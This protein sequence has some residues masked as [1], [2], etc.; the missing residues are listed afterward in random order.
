M[1]ARETGHVAGPGHPARPRSSGASSLQPLDWF[2]VIVPTALAAALLLYDLGGRSLWLDEA[3][4]FTTASQHGSALW[5][6]ALND[7]GNMVLYYLGM[8]VVTGALGTSEITLRL[9]SALAAIATVPTAFFLLRRLFDRRAA[10]FGAAFEAV[11]MPVVYWGQQARGYSV[12]AF[13][14]SASTL[15]FVVAVQDK[16]RLAYVAYVV[17]SV[18]AVY[19]VLLS[20]LVLVAHVASLLAL[21]PDQVPRRQL[22]ACY[23]AICVLC[24]PVGLVA[25]AHGTAPVDWVTPFGS[26]VGPAARGLVEFL[27]SDSPFWPSAHTAA[28]LVIIAMAALWVY[29]ALLWSRALAHR[30]KERTAA[31]AYGLLIAWVACPVVI[32]YLVSA[33]VHPILVDR[34][35]LDTLP[36]ASMLAGVAC[37]RLRPQPLAIGTGAALLV[38]RA[39][40]TVPSY[41]APLEDWRGAEIAVL[42]RS[43]PGDCVAFFTSDGYMPFDYYVLGRPRDHRLPPTPVLPVSSWASRAPHVLEP[44]FIP[45]RRMH[46]VVASCPRLWLLS[47]H[48]LSAPPGPGTGL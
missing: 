38:L 44:A 13:L 7:G 8:H 33:L 15:A 43:L 3:D 30:A 42:D 22:A 36:A 26:L 31:W 2:A 47:S 37:A 29:A 45:G 40:V 6:W 32:S 48:I 12:A 19:T 4:T 41:G 1:T 46:E 25:L 5:H 11:S 14:V 39:W 23:G 17:L 16:R 34:Y 35:L 21:R 20:A 10:V 9:P 24:V 28:H 18:L 27:A